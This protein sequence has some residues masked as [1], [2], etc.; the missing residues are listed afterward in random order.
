MQETARCSRPGTLKSR[1]S[2]M[3]VAAPRPLSWM[4]SRAQM[5]WL[6][7]C[8][9]VKTGPCSRV[10]PLSGKHW[11]LVFAVHFWWSLTPVLFLG[12]FSSRSF[13]LLIGHYLY[14][15][16]VCDVCWNQC[17]PFQYLVI[18]C[19]LF[20][21]CSLKQSLYSFIVPTG[22]TFKMK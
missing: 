15:I 17:F 12:L 5:Q 16:C 7:M 6:G 13:L 10:L 14:F 8:Q 19:L 2:V 4:S 18:L 3:L 22:R 21:V 20:Y 9:R 11:K 1:F